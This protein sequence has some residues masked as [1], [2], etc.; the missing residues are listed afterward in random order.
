MFFRLNLFPI[1]PIFFTGLPYYIPYP[2]SLFFYTSSQQR[3]SALFCA[4]VLYLIYP[5]FFFFLDYF[6]VL[7]CSYFF[8]FFLSSLAHLPIRIAVPLF[9]MS[10]IPSIITTTQFLSCIITSAYTRLFI[11]IGFICSSSPPSFQICF[12]VVPAP[13]FEMKCQMEM[14]LSMYESRFPHNFTPLFP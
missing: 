8:S 7:T 2:P 12:V 1:P 6:F 13:C 11:Y 14:S 3:R 5:P 9:F 10:V 4:C